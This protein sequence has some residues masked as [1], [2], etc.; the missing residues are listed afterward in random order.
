MKVESLLFALTG[1]WVNASDCVEFLDLLLALVVL[2]GLWVVVVVVVGLS[3]EDAVVVVGLEAVEAV[4][5]V[6][7]G[8]L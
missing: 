1:F 7:E 2:A 4:V 5:V 6:L 8:G 3:V